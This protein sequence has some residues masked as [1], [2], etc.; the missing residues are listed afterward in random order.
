MGMPVGNLV[1]HF[2]VLVRDCEV[3]EPV[4]EPRRPTGSQRYRVKTPMRFAG[5]ELGKLPGGLASGFVA[6]LL[7]TFLS[8]VVDARDSGSITRRQGATLSARPGVLDPEGWEQANSALRSA[9]EEIEM[10]EAESRE[11]LKALGGT[12]AIHVA[13]GIALFEAAPPA[14]LPR[15]HPAGGDSHDV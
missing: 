12:A 6:V 10:V 2:N 1:Y 4:Q 11:R 14:N 15:H 8:L 3:L 13:L 5:L 9:E 7:E